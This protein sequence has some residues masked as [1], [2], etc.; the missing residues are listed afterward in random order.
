MSPEQ[1][2]GEKELDGRSDVYSLGATIFEMLTGQTPYNAD[3]PGK[4]MLKHVLEPVPCISTADPT[5]PAGCDAII[6]RALAKSRDDRYASVDDLADDL[7]QLAATATA[8][9]PTMIDTPPPT[10]ARRLKLSAL[11]PL[12]LPHHPAPS[13]PSPLLSVQFPTGAP[14]AS[15]RAGGPIA[16][17]VVGAILIGIIALGGPFAVSQLVALY[18]PTTNVS[19]LLP[20]RL[21]R[22]YPPHPLHSTHPT[23]F[24]SPYPHHTRSALKSPKKMNGHSLRA[25]RRNDGS[26]DSDSKRAMKTTAHRLPRRFWI[27][28]TEVT[29][30]MYAVCGSRSMPKPWWRRLH[31]QLGL[32]HGTMLRHIVNGL[33]DVCPRNWWEKAARV[34]MGVLPST[35]GHLRT[36]QHSRM[37]RTRQQV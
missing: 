15:R 19:R 29:N 8:T 26:S 35:S 36:S 30:K 28:Q 31:Y 18:R 14:G 27:D 1:V 24:Y 5:L 23:N 33:A 6:L 9:A 22:G 3:T 34:Q 17:L 11:S 25:C 21:L 32:S 2:Q 7:T 16:A 13:T 12:T 10:P 4:L 20:P 37:W